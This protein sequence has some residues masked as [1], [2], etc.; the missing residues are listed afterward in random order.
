MLSSW[1]HRPPPPLA[2]AVFCCACSSEL[3]KLDATVAL[4]VRAVTLTNERLLI[5]MTSDQ[6]IKDLLTKVDTA[7][8]AISVNISTE[9]I[10]LQ[11]VANEMNALL[12]QSKTG[13]LS[14]ATIADFQVRIDKLGEISNSVSANAAAAKLIATNG[15]ASLTPPLPPTTT[16]DPLPPG[17]APSV[18][19]QP[20]A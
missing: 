20:A 4:L 19:A 3:A 7:T 18:T 14:D 6:Q 8:T 12:A 5:I 13:V 17:V 15:I 11:N 10:T 1:F 9:A 2:P 16:P